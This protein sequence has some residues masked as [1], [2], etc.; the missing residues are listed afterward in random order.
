MAGHH[1][2]QARAVLD[3]HAGHFHALLGVDHR[4]Q[5]T[6]NRGQRLGAEID[7]V[8]DEVNLGGLGPAAA[9]GLDLVHGQPVDAGDGVGGIVGV[10]HGQAGI[11]DHR[12]VRYQVGLFETAQETHLEELF[13][14][15]VGKDGIEALG[16]GQVGP[17]LEGIVLGHVAD[18]LIGLAR[19]HP[20]VTGGGQRTAGR[21]RAVHDHIAAERTRQ[22]GQ[23]MVNRDPAGDQR[24]AF[25]CAL[26]HVDHGEH[27]VDHRRIG[28]GL[29]VAVGQGNEAVLHQAVEEALAGGAAGGVGRQGGVIHRGPVAMSRDI[30]HGDEPL[31]E[32]GGN[33]EAAEAAFL[34]GPPQVI[35]RI[36]NTGDV[37]LVQGAVV[38]IV[39]VVG[40]PIADLYQ[41]GLDG[42]EL[43]AHLHRIDIGLLGGDGGNPVDHRLQDKALL[44]LVVAGDDINGGELG[45]EIGLGELEIVV[46]TV[47]KGQKQ[48]IVRGGHGDVAGGVP[49]AMTGPHPALGRHRDTAAAVGAGGQGDI[50]GGHHLAAHQ[51]IVGAVED[52]GAAH[53]VD[54]RITGGDGAVGADT[55]GVD[56]DLALG[57]HQGAEIIALAAGDKDVARVG[58]GRAVGGEVDRRGGG[59]GSD[60][61]LVH[62]PDIGGGQGDLIAGVDQGVAAGVEGAAGGGGDGTGIH[63]RLAGGGIGVNLAHHAVQPQVMGGVDGDG[64][65][66]PG[67]ELAAADAVRQGALVK[68]AGEKR[69]G[70]GHRLAAAQPRP[71]G[72]RAIE[73]TAEDHRIAAG[74]RGGLAQGNEGGVDAPALGVDEMAVG[75][76]EVLIG[77]IV[78]E[79]AAVAHQIAILVGEVGGAADLLGGANG[80]H[81]VEQGPVAIDEQAVG[82]D[83]I[84]VSVDA[85][86]A[87]INE[88]S[89]AINPVAV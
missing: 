13:R 68:D 69:Q 70:P 7:G 64:A 73:A 33:V 37:I 3:H 80:A 89:V 24:S 87:D 52:D 44:H 9:Q 36:I 34:A 5:I 32:Q 78:D 11:G 81:A 19:T 56:P 59:A 67:C 25:G 85:V 74:H 49:V 38:G 63:H 4:G 53:P 14:A 17:G 8:V 26:L 20:G 86:A 66:F 54:G 45:A 48:D 83:E 79:M 71:T 82:V 30:G 61:A 88:V 29:T 23:D 2:I 22:V 6:V 57:R 55:G 15:P 72:H 60:H 21:N 27:I 84:A 1:H 28:H 10:D 31:V 58:G 16:I 41:A 77:D 62:E 65:P 18:I 46:G 75:V 50:T 40:L 47:L 43:A 35:D 39:R 51:E 42:A 12:D 76:D